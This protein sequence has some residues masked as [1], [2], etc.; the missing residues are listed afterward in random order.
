[1]AQVDAGLRLIDQAEDERLRRQKRIMQ[2]QAQTVD[3]LIAQGIGRVRAMKIVAAREKKAA[4]LDAVLENLEA[5]RQRSGLPC[6]QEFGVTLQEVR[7]LKPKE[8]QALLD[9]TAQPL[10]FSQAA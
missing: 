5:A 1:M 6:Y 9:R 10:A 4:L 8:L 3:Q 7:R 2:G